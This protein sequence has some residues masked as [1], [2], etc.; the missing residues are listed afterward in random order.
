MNFEIII[1]K[2]TLQQGGIVSTANEIRE[3]NRE[4]NEQNVEDSGLDEKSD[5]SDNGGEE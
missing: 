5:N 2:C 1:W 3:E 4:N